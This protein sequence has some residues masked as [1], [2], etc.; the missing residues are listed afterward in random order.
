MP[1]QFSIGILS[2]ELP[3]NRLAFGI[4][5]SLPSVDLALQQSGRGDAAIQSL[6]IEDTDFDLRLVEPAGV[7]G[8]VVEPNSSQEL[9]RMRLPSTSPKHFLKWV[10]R[11][12]RTR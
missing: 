8:G 10:F 1:T 2:S 4:A 7:F 11:L 3:L 5:V 12:S 6:A 9:G